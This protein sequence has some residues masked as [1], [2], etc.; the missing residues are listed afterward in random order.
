MLEF[1]VRAMGKR[2]RT[3][4]VGRHFHI[5]LS[6]GSRC[7]R[8]AGSREVKHQGTARLSEARPM[9]HAQ[10]MEYWKNLP[11]LTKN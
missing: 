6:P 8:I 4:G 5:Y 3:I 7:N 2:P 1:D 11:Y 9:D 10:M